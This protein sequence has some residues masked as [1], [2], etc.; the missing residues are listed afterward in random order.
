MC[1]VF[2]LRMHTHDQAL[3][4]S[5]AELVEAW[6]VFTPVL[7]HI[8]DERPQPVLHPF[9][10]LPEGYVAWTESHGVDIAPPARHWGAAEAEA[11]AAK[12]EA[13]A[14]ALASAVE[15]A[16]AAELRKRDPFSDAS[17]VF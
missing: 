8:D 7:H 4:V 11:H 3:S 6:R 1:G 16:E 14:A 10:E 2:A 9:G 13:A 15:K 12:E 5:A 17:F